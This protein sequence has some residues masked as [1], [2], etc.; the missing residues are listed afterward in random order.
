MR[1]AGQPILHRSMMLSTS[2]GFS[3]EASSAGLRPGEWP[4]TVVVVNDAGEGE[5]AFVREA[6]RV[7]GEN[8][9]LAYTYRGLFSGQEL[10]IFND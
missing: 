2:T 5:Q 8:E 9:L 3:I 4:E 6:A 10:V 7:R 1:T